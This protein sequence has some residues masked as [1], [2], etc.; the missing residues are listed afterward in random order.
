MAVAIAPG[1]SQPAKKTA[2]IWFTKDREDPTIDVDEPEDAVLLEEV[3]ESV[4]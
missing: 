2:L 4:G 1:N 3:D